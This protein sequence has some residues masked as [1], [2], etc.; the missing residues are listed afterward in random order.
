MAQRDDEIVV[1]RDDR[2]LVEVELAHLGYRPNRGSTS[3]VIFTGAPGGITA[4]PLLELLRSRHGTGLRIGPHRLLSPARIPRGFD[5]PQPSA[6]K[7]PGFTGS[8][9]GVTIG[10]ID[11]GVVLRDRQAHEFLRGR[12]LFDEGDVDPEGRDNGGTSDGH[13]TFVAGVV[14]GEAPSVTVRMKG[15]IDTAT[16]KWEDNA[17]ASAICSL[18]EEVDLI[19]LSFSGDPYETETPQIIADALRA[20]GPDVVVVAAS[21]NGGS[22]REV[23][24]AAVDLGQDHPWILAV[25][26]G[27]EHQRT[28]GNEPP[29][30]AG[31]SGHGDWVRAYANGSHVLGPFGADEWRTW[32]GTSFAAAIVTGRIAATMAERGVT[33]KRAA[34]QVIEHAKEHPIQDGA[35]IRPYV[36]SS[37][38]PVP[39][40]DETTG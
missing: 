3:H 6:L 5:D 17:V 23:Y 27:D 4:L 15:V 34:Q 35:L 14:L 39:I 40:T 26:A 25:G 7:L 24:P 33:A 18:S 9:S 31:F 28:G 2:T 1:H 12:V 37:A 8:P 13:G 38:R 22:I 29:T 30:V 19:N 11:T 21:G 32:S 16:D 10:V 20:L 36:R